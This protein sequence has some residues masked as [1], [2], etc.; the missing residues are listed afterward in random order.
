M[1]LR[2]LDRFLSGR[3]AQSAPERFRRMGIQPISADFPVD[4]A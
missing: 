4:L 3:H 1:L 2:S